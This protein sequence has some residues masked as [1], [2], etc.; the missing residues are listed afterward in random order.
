MNV[1]PSSPS[2]VPA[3]DRQWGGLA[4]GHTYLLVGADSARTALAF[5]TVK[6]AVDAGTA[7]LVISPRAPEA[8]VETARGVGLDLG[9]AHKAG[10]LRLLRIPPADTLAARGADGLA[11]S[12]RDLAG[13]VER[14]RPGRVVIEDF[15]PLVQFEDVER[16]RA[17]LS[18]LAGGLLDLEATLVIGLP[19]PD[20]DLGR[21]RLEVV[22][23][24]ADG[25]VRFDEH[26]A[27]VLDTLP[28]GGG[29][30]E[31]VTFQEIEAAPLPSSDGASVE[32]G[33]PRLPGLPLPD[34]AG[35]GEGWPPPTDIVPPP[36]PD[37]SLLTPVTTDAFGG[38]P[39]DAL[40]EQG[41]LADSSTG[42]FPPSAPSSAEPPAPF[43][44]PPQPWEPPADPPPAPVA[45][46]AF[47]PLGTAGLGSPPPAATF[48]DHLEAAFLGRS[49][50]DPFLVVAVRMEPSQPE[51]AHFNA[52]GEGLR[53]SIRPTDHVLI[54]E[55]RKRAMVL[56]PGAGADAGQ[57]LF[58][59]L[60]AHLRTALGPEADP[61][62][63][64]V[65]AVTVPDGQPFASAQ[66]LMAY[67]FE[68]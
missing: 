34:G 55:D 22:R 37:P 29:S 67:A 10:Q 33:G 50:D 30:E 25:T 49:S 68:S 13:L 14:N 43:S 51:A 65:A 24:L 17:V 45:L 26:G 6:A 32:T 62:L 11:K 41:F 48:R 12:Y 1:A 60:Q 31:D 35:T 42:T 19:E 18:D 16:L 23:S 44:L 21:Q 20:D 39:A 53:A 27:V 5:Q 56:M 28:E 7:S 57:S 46:P 58:T 47:A 64:A 38:D 2:G 8:L 63:G 52:V 40:M 59:S 36:S 9:R 3:V 15:T 61:V 4:A 54:D 66:D